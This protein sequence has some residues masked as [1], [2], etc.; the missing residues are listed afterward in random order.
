MAHGS[1]QKMQVIL[2]ALFPDLGSRGGI[3]PGPFPAEREVDPVHIFHQLQRRV[4]PDIFMQRTA[5]IVRD[6]VLAVGKSPRSAETAHNGAARAVN[7]FLYFLSVDGA[8]AFFQLMS[9]LKH[10]DLQIRL[11]PRQL[12]RGKD[13]AR[14]GSDNDHVIHVFILLTNRLSDRQP[15]FF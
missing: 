10:G 6:V 7:A 8:A 11:F 5:E 13:P 9:H 12:K 14:S 15:V 3:Q 1:I 4:L 2:Q